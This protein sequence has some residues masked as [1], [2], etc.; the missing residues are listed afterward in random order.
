MIVLETSSYEE[1]LEYLEISVSELYWDRKPNEFLQLPP[2]TGISENH[3]M[4]VY[5]WGRKAWHVTDTEKNCLFLTLPT[6]WH[7]IYRFFFLSF[8]FCLFLLRYNWCT[9]LY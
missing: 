6:L 8:F 9:V 3:I 2:V 4:L 1:L 7:F 5:A